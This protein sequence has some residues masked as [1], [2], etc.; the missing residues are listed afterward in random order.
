[1]DYTPEELEL[2][3]SDASCTSPEPVK[4]LGR[5]MLKQQLRAFGY[6]NTEQLQSADEIRTFGGVDIIR[7]EV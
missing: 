3:L 7:I 6:E 1:M 4:K 2:M 5:E